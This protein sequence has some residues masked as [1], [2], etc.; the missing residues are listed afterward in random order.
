MKH[1]SLMGLSL[2]L[3]LGF[4]PVSAPAQVVGVEPW[5]TLRATTVLP[6][7][8][9]V[10]RQRVGDVELH[11]A[12]YGKGRPVILLHPGLGH[13]DYWANQIGP[14]S[15]AYQVVVVDL[16][17]HG[18][19]TTSDRPLSYGLMAEDLLGLIQKLHLS[20]P[21]VVGWGDGGVVALELA[22]RHPGRIGKLIIFGAPYSPAG[23][24]TGVDR[25]PTFIEYVHK[26]GAD[27]DRLSPAPGSFDRLFLQL[28][29]M[30]GREPNYTAEQLGSIK[31]PT[32]IIMAE[33]DEWVRMEHV[34]RMATM[35]PD[36][37]LL[38]MAKV[39]HF[40]PWQAPKKFNDAVR[41]A[42]EF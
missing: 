21:A 39:S 28:E 33:Y 6:P 40:A 30:W 2:A 41:I 14:L 22:L 26:T 31:A 13:G 37:R 16:R 1:R 42:L 15:Q 34:E 35:I 5:T 17:G 27:H 8:R 4:A 10:G 20:K 38:P 25:R 29:G 11:Y 12:I 23:L 36:A 7:A 3:A 24:Q 18:R 32:T 19:S 9:E